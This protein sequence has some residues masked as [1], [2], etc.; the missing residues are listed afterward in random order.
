MTPSRDELL[1]LSDT[2]LFRKCQCDTFR[3]TGPGGQH[4]NTTDSAV[5]L[6][7]IGTSISASAANYRSQHRNKS[8]ALKKLRLEIAFAVRDPNAKPWKE[9][10]R[11][12]TSNPDYPLFIAN[13]L[14][15]LAA[16]VFRISD[17]AAKLGISTGKLNRILAR[18]P[19]VWKHVNDRRQ[20]A[21]LKSLKSG[22]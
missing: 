14:D 7:L 13:L 17:A 15:I 21:G 10:P 12:A 16:T 19:K 22:K 1:R 4:R 11:V 20:D 9:P 5:R 6:T 8:A 2:D 3:G 18:D